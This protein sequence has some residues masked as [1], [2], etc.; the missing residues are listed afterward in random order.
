MTPID[1][2]L[3][4][5][6]KVTRKGPDAWMACCPAHDDRHPSLSVKETEDGTVLFK[7]WAECSAPEVIQALGIEAKDLFPPRPETTT[8]KR[9]R[10]R[11]VP[12]DALEALAVDA[13]YVSIC[14]EDLA[15][16][17]NLKPMER[18]RLLVAS[19]RFLT[20]YQEVGR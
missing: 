12:R 19:R 8:G 9:R 20:A 5:L 14:A 17:E 6:D 15:K 7:C 1:L 4:R 13:L 16:G 11:W 2:F 10:I 18:E 3:S